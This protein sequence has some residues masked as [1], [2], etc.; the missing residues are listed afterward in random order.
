MIPSE[1]SFGGFN[2]NAFK[3]AQVAYYQCKTLPAAAR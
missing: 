2:A 1:M 3:D